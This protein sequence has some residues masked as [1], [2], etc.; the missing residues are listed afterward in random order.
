MHHKAHMNASR[1]VGEVLDPHISI[2]V[3]STSDLV[4]FT[5]IRYILNSTMYIHE[6]MLFSN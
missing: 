4:A 2:H 6:S 5:N 3:E 1:K